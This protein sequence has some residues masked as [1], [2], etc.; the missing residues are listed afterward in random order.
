MSALLE[1]FARHEQMVSQC[2]GRI[3]SAGEPDILNL[4]HLAGHQCIVLKQPSL[5]P[6]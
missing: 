5:I 6:Q 2:G 4:A 1:A 3:V